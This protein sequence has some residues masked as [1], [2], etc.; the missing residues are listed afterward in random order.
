VQPGRWLR[1]WRACLQQ[2]VHV[3]QC[4]LFIKLFTTP[5][6]GEAS[7]PV[8]AGFAAAAR[9]AGT[10]SADDIP[11]PDTPFYRGLKAILGRSGWQIANADAWRGLMLMGEPHMYGATT[12]IQVPRSMHVLSTA[13]R[14][15][16][17]GVWKAGSGWWR[18]KS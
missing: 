17:Q 10:P 3:Q 12:R 9:R 18:L 6:Q 1:R 7:P 11:E 8:S 5:L 4:Q 14:A 13:Q 16:V 2:H 15:V